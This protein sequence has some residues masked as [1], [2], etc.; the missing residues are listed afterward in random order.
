M[1]THPRLFVDAYQ[2]KGMWASEWDVWFG[3]RREL[4]AQPAAIG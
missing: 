1:Y 3:L 4:R 2:R